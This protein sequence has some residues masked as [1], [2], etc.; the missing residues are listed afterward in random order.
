MTRRRRLPF[1]FLAPSLVLMALLFGALVPTAAGEELTPR[2]GTSPAAEPASPAETRSAPMPETTCPSCND[3]NGCNVDFCDESTGTCRHE[4]RNCDDGNPCTRDGCVGPPVSAIGECYHQAYD[5]G[6]T[7]DDGSACTVADQCLSGACVGQALQPASPC[8]DGNSCTAGDICDDALHCAGSPLSAG[9]ACDDRSACTS[10]DH[11]ADSDTGPLCVGIQLDCA[12]LD[13][14]TQDLCDPAT[15]QC[16]HAP[17]NCD[18]GN[19][20]TI[21][22]C[23]PAT[24]LCR[25]EHRE[26]TCSDANPCTQDTCVDGN[27]IAGAGCPPSSACVS[28][29]CDPLLGCISTNNSGG[30]C[31]PPDAPPDDCNLYQCV[32]GGCQAVF[33][34]PCNDNNSCT[35]DHCPNHACTYTPLPD[36]GACHAGGAC[37]TDGI[38][39]AGQCLG[40]TPVSCNDGNPCTTD[41][42]DPVSGC[43]HVAAVCDDH[44]ECTRDFCSLATGQCI[45]DPQSNTP[46]GNTDGDVCTTDY[47][48]DGACAGHG[49]LVCDDGNLCTVDLCDPSV[50]CRHMSACNDNNP[51]T[52]DSCVSAMAGCAHTSVVPGTRCNDGDPCTSD[53]ACVTGPAG[54]LV[55]RGTGANCDDGNPCTTDLHDETCEECI[56]LPMNSGL[57]DDGNACTAGDHCEAGVC[58]PFGQQTCDDGNPCTADSCDVVAGC[59]HL[60]IAAPATCGAGACERTIDTC[61]GGVFHACVPGAPSPE[62]C[63]GVDDDCDGNVDEERVTMSC[64]A[65]PSTIRVQAKGSPFSMTCAIQDACG[66][67]DGSG[68]GTVPQVVMSI[69][70]AWI[71]AADSLADPSDN[72]FYADPATLACPDGQRNS[73]FE[74]GIAENQAARSGDL[75]AMVFRFNIPADG[76][77]ATLDGDRQEVIRRLLG[78]RDGETAR[79][80]A[81]TRVDGVQVEGCATVAVRGT[82]RTEGRGDGRTGRARPLP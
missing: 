5:N 32:R 22:S 39:A 65:S 38:C 19:G 82:S 68:G 43:R 69:D 72:Q 81:S 2:K 36:G 18:D 21:D 75:S 49:G 24:G 60:A 76:Q 25:R 47:C 51:C 12:D 28:V 6:T 70:R 63:N 62:V 40:G 64:T 9:T 67:G 53:E 23:D 41:S 66:G 50:G 54:T 45:F 42:C 1:S 61:A 11:C 78:L 35:L 33:T 73:A 56:N 80:C 79:I 31:T 37:V 34:I 16:Q 74:R 26:G 17:V 15:G 27:C 58:R 52:N 8:D 46:C 57:C 71:S 77:C 48:V 10:G 7:C 14:C 30:A 13:L 3:F 59:G 29:R 20:C 55:C 4:P 44:N